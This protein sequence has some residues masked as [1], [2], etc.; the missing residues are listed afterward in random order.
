[1]TAASPQRKTGPTAVHRAVLPITHHARHD[2][3]HADITFMEV[4]PSLSFLYGVTPIGD[5]RDETHYAN[6]YRA[7][8]ALSDGVREE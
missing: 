7:Y 8:D 6:C 2:T 4:P 5:E 1:M 3:W